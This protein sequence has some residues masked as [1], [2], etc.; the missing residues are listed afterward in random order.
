MAT[1]DEEY[2]DVGLKIEEKVLY[3][4]R[5]QLCCQSPVFREMFG[6]NWG[7]RDEDIIP[8]KGKKLKEFM[9]FL[10]LVGNSIPPPLLIPYY[11]VEMLDLL[12][13]YMIEH[14]KVLSEGENVYT[15]L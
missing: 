6:E 4:C 8:L 10:A 13:E 9:P 3:P 5:G 7:E 14:L 2:R 12:R 11:T 15:L 1:R